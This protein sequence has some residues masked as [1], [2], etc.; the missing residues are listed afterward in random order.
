MIFPNSV[1]LEDFSELPSSLNDPFI[2]IVVPTVDVFQKKYD[3]FF[4]KACLSRMC[5]QTISEIV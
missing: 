1:G 2:L 5:V 4:A 3:L